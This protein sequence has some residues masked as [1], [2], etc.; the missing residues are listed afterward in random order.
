[1]QMNTKHKK[2]KKYLKL[3][4]ESRKED[5]QSP[6]WM[7]IEK[8]IGSD[9]DLFALQKSHFYPPPPKNY[10]KWHNKSDRMRN[11]RV[12]KYNL[13]QHFKVITVKDNIPNFEEFDAEQWDDHYVH[14]WIG[15]G[16]YLEEDEKEY[17][18]HHRNRAKW[19]FW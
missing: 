1:M 17:S 8:I 4:N 13:K 10:I 5:F 18:Y 3:R 11:K 2:Y 9:N 12:L 16:K 14:R 7:E 6:R 15:K 19:D